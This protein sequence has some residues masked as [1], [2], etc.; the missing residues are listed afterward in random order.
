MGNITKALSA[1]S[2]A[3]RGGLVHAKKETKVMAQLS[4]L[5]HVQEVRS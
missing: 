4:D 2:K 3:I 1:V 5:Q